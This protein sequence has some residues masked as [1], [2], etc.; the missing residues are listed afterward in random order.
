[1]ITDT[2]KLSEVFIV[3]TKQQCCTFATSHMYNML[4]MCASFVKHSDLSTLF[5]HFIIII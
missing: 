2:N 1:M 4:F 5:K 3:A